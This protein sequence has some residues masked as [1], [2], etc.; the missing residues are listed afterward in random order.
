MTYIQFPYNLKQNVASI[1]KSILFEPTFRL[2]KIGTLFEPTF[3][4]RLSKIGA[5]LKAL[6][7]LGLAKFLI[8]FFFI[9]FEI[10]SG[11]TQFF[12]RQPIPGMALNCSEIRSL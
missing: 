8:L 6:L 1:K 11:I 9:V 12:A 7:G 2:S 3:R 10:Q 4:L 5:F